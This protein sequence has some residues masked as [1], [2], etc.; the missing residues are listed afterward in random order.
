MALGAWR[1]FIEQLVGRFSRQRQQIFDMEDEIL[2]RRDRLIGD[3]E[4][5][6]AQKTSSAPLFT[7]RW[8]VA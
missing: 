5:R 7:L 2:G 1:I 6:L 3:L 4:K 8:S